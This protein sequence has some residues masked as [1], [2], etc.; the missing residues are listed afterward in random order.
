MVGIV[1]K[2]QKLPE[3]SC[4]MCKVEESSNELIR[5][6]KVVNGGEKEWKMDIK[7]EKIFNDSSKLDKLRGI[8]SRKAKQWMIRVG[9]TIL[10]WVILLHITTMG[11]FWR[12]NLM[13]SW[14]YSL[15]NNAFNLHMNV[16]K[17]PMLP[18]IALPPKSKFFF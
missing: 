10:F 17:L 16:E 6:R 5:E 1:E 9:T 7:L 8:R 2:K 18:K 4:I 12:P 14:P 11:N 3:F 15:K 13:K